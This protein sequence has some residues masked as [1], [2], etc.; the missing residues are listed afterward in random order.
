MKIRPAQDYHFDWMPCLSHLWNLVRKNLVANVRSG[1]DDVLANINISRKCSRSVKWLA[2]QGQSRNIA[3]YPPTRWC[4]ACYAIESVST[5][6]MNIRTRTPKRSCSLTL[7]NSWLSSQGTS[8]GYWRNQMT[9]CHHQT[10]GTGWPWVL[11]W[12]IRCISSQHNLST[13]VRYVTI[14]TSF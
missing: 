11:V 3:G 13:S 4:T 5:L 12:L 14:C 9:G 7:M 1:L 2:T 8:F 6:S 10:S